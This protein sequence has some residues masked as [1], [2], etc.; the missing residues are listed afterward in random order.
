M[1]EREH[2]VPQIRET[3]TC[4][5]GLDSLVVEVLVL[6]GIGAV[7]REGGISSRYY[8]RFVSSIYKY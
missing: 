6:Q 3:R 8:L 7:A 5:T 1:E 4:A 2:G